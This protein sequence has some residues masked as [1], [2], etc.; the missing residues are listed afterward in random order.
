MIHTRRSR[1]THATQAHWM[2][3]INAKTRISSFFSFIILCTYWRFSFSVQRTG[4]LSRTAR[5]QRKQWADQMVRASMHLPDRLLAS[6]R[7]YELKRCVILSYSKV[8]TRQNLKVGRIVI[9][10]ESFLILKSLISPERLGIRVR[11]PQDH[12]PAP[13]PRPCRTLYAN[14]C[15]LNF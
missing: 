11:K 1:V 9:M 13:S 7:R 6:L 2:W 5:L 14:I 12:P 3:K 15:L 4:S 8:A 10:N